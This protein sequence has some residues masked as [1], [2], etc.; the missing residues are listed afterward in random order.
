MS[1]ATPGSPAP[2]SSL[3]V[4]VPSVTLSPSGEEERPLLLPSRT[5][6]RRSS[7]G[8]ERKRSSVRVNLGHEPGDSAPPSPLLGMDHQNHQNRNQDH[9]RD[10]AA[11]AGYLL[12][13][14]LATN[15]NVG[16]G[17]KLRE[18]DSAE[19]LGGAELCREA[20]LRGETGLRG[21]VNP[22]FSAE[23]TAALLLRAVCSSRTHIQQDPITA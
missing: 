13:Q 17:E 23:S 5:A 22:L 3:A 14:L 2:L 18:G 7:G 19:A 11:A 21:E 1:L 10:H 8:D 15:N 9:Q 4:S 6:A 20:G 16:D 12:S